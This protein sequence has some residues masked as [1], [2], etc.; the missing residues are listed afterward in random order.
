MVHFWREAEHLIRLG[1]LFLAFVVLFLVV[2]AALIPPGFGELGHF[3][4]GALLDNRIRTPVFAGRE[5]CADCHDDVGSTLAAGAHAK[6]SCES[7]HGPLRGHVDD[8]ST[9]KP[10][11]LAV[12]QLCS[13][14]H[15][16]NPARPKDHPQIDIE[17]HREGAACSDCHDAHA[18]AL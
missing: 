15:A 13:L 14:C 8:P 6:V 2:R 10:S 5:A 12:V 3:R 18:P 11:A 9:A 1:L 17:P 7:C 16:A 4:P